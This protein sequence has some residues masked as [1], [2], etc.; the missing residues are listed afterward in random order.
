MGNNCLTNLEINGPQQEAQYQCAPRGDVLPWSDK[1]FEERPFEQVQQEE[2]GQVIKHMVYMFKDLYMGNDMNVVR[3]NNNLNTR[4]EIR[5]VGGIFDIQ[6]VEGSIDNILKTD[7]GQKILN[8]T[9]GIDLKE[10][11]FP[12]R[13]DDYFAWKMETKIWDELP[14]QE[15]R[16]IV[17]DVKV[18]PN[19]DKR[20]WNIAI[21]YDVEA[22]KAYGLT[23]STIL[24]GTGKNRSADDNNLNEYSE[25]STVDH[26]DPNTICSLGPDT[27][28]NPPSIEPTPS[29]ITDGYSMF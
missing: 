29:I 27:C 21:T 12:E 22:L 15:L 18:T 24:N 25:A 14:G 3:R 1:F 7:P 20:E 13:F 10:F 17:Q 23:W 28:F 2:R 5:D 9:F 8:P 4:S 11:I 6:S 26:Q 19:P 16:I